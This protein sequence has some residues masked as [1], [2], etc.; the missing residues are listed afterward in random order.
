MAL[1]ILVR[2][3]RQEKNWGET[4]KKEKT[5]LWMFAH[6]MIAYLKP[7]DN[8]LKVHCINLKAE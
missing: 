5:K 4:I 1:E 3:I 2:A 8:Q 6:D 7:Q